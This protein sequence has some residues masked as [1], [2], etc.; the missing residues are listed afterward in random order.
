[1]RSKLMKLKRSLK[2]RCRMVQSKIYSIICYPLKVKSNK[3]V[4]DNFD[5]KGFGCN[6]K[7][8][9]LELKKRNPLYDLV[10]IVNNTNE[11]F[12]DGIRC[13]KRGT[14]RAKYE[15]ATAS[16]WIDNVRST[17]R[18]FKKRNQKY[19]QTWHATL[20]LKKIEAESPKESLQPDYEKKARQDGKLIDLMF[21]D[22]DLR[23][24]Q[25]KKFFWYTGPV[26]K[27][28]VPRNEPLF[29]NDL[30]LKRRVYKALGIEEGK[31]IVLYVPTFRKK[32]ND[33]KVYGF[34]Y[35]ECIN[36]LSE[37]FG[38]EFVCLI[39]MHPNVVHISQ[40]IQYDS[41]I[42]NATY[43]DDVQELLAVS[44]VIITDYSSCMFDF[45]FTGKPVFIL[46]KDLHEY[47]QN[48]QGMRLD[49]RSMP[50]PISYTETDLLHQ[51]SIFDKAIYD[52]KCK[53]FFDLIGLEEDGKG[54]MKIA[55]I[56]E[57]WI[58]YGK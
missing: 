46:A 45:A 6:P 3:I 41:H 24:E 22:N 51:I 15:W 18:G 32:L 50:F 13:V 39:R 54:A 4:F 42:I 9:A 29:S 33:R 23:I 38:G 2:K 35:E 36:S 20:G 1:M 30:K 47:Q 19:I 5:G 31:K 48:D 14:L 10:W 11:Y 7:Y 28:G 27:C 55:D 52:K 34:D 58:R 26:I 49:L 56:I 43:Y 8:I 37:K 44:D 17:D 53:T 57:E 16:V 21:A 12:P 40:E 25:F